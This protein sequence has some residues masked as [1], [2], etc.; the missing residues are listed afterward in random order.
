MEKL[1]WNILECKEKYPQCQNFGDLIHAVEKE[2]MDED[3][4]VCHVRVNGLDLTDEDEKKFADVEVSEIKELVIQV[5]TISHVISNALGGV[6]QLIPG[7]V[8]EA[9][10]ISEFFR[11]PE[12]VPLSRILTLI[13]GYQH[14]IDTVSYVGTI[15]VG[16]NREWKCLD[17]WQK[18]DR[19][20]SATIRE[21]LE[22]YEK[23][24]Y[25]MLADVM[26]Y[27]LT[28]SLKEWSCVIEVMQADR[29]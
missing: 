18:A 4:V 7:L 8:N 11:G 2:C 14:I 24:D 12:T 28:E 3:K 22:S 6:H 1:Q 15:E 21:L 25:L 23:R 5:D 29:S 20:A 9:L 13:D 10:E 19:H 26:E 17:V 27:E 16:K